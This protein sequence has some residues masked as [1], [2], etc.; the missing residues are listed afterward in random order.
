MVYDGFL[1]RWLHRSAWFCYGVAEVHFRSNFWGRNL[2]V[3]KTHKKNVKFTSEMTIG[4][5]ITITTSY[6]VVLCYES[7]LEISE[8]SKTKNSLFWSFRKF[9]QILV[10]NTKYPILKFENV[11]KGLNFPPSKILSYSSTIK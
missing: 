6:F 11:S 9:V 1:G 4:I 10:T 8:H 3:R 7:G 5:S 2:K